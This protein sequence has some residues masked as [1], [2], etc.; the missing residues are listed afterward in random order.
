MTDEQAVPAAP[1]NA[2]AIHPKVGIPAFVGALVVTLIGVVKTNWGIDLSGYEAQLT[3]LA[4]A[5]AGYL[6]PS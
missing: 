6:V 4:M 2:R 1:L 5:V 3:V